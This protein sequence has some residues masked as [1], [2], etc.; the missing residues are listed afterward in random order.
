MRNFALSGGSEKRQATRM[1]IQARVWVANMV[2]GH[3][4]QSFTALSRDVSIA[5]VGLMQ[6]SPSRIGD[7]FLAGLP[8]DKGELV[9]RCQTMYCQS[10][11]EG[12]FGIGARFEGIADPTLIAQIRKVNDTAAARIQ[13]A[14]LG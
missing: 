9:L 3:V 1:E 12:V 7:H 6:R 4:T 2:D 5:G 11:A 10:L 8:F 14:I 13:Q